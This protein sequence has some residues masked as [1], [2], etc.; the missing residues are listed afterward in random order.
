[1]IFQIVT[2]QKYHKTVLSLTH[3]IPMA[4]HVGV[5]KTHHQMLQHFYWPGIT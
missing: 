1:M 3:D 4:G 5:G 2:P